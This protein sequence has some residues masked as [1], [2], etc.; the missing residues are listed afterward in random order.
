[1]TPLPKHLGCEHHVPVFDPADCRVCFVAISKLDR[2]SIP[3][4]SSFSNTV[5]TSLAAQY[6]ILD[7]PRFHP[8]FDLYG[9]S[10]PGKES[11]YSV[12]TSIEHVK[13]E[14]TFDARLNLIRLGWW[15]GGVLRM[16]EKRYRQLWVGPIPT[17]ERS[18]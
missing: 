11:T 18:D 9:S 10:G 16:L 2:P 4:Q 13:V 5:L 3:L 7:I 1:M 14:Q 17:R 6:T 8:R 12:V 15:R